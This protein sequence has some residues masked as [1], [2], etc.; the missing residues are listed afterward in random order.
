MR[1]LLTGMNEKSKILVWPLVPDIISALLHGL[2]KFKLRRNCAMALATSVLRLVIAALVMISALFPGQLLL[3]NAAAQ[4]ESER[5]VYADFEKIENGRAVSNNGGLIQIFTSQESTPLQFKGQANA[6]PGAPELVVSKGDVKNHVATFE[7]TLTNPNQ[8]ANV[9]LEVQGHP[10]QD[11][12]PV[13][14]DMSAYKNLS[15]QLYATGTDDL[16][17]EFISHGQ[18]INLNAGFPQMSIRLKPG[19]NTY[20]I[21]FKSLSQPSWVDHR[22][23]SKDVL[24]KLTAVSISVFCNQCVPQHGI[25]AVDNLVFQK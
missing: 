20:L 17:I 8:W 3:R 23:D 2:T 6:S 7:Y 1:V 24:K 15:I 16:R 25:V 12:K 19:L 4:S 5:M 18:G 11:G 21:P 9:T 13:A 22:V 14:D 10:N